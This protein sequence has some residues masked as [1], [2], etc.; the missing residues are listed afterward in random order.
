MFNKHV[1]NFEMINLIAKN[2]IRVRR[3][4]EWLF[5]SFRKI[6]LFRFKSRSILVSVVEFFQSFNFFVVFIFV[7]Y[8]CTQSLSNIFAIKNYSQHCIIQ[9]SIITIILCTYALT[10]FKIKEIR[11]FFIHLLCYYHQK[12]VLNFW[13]DHLITIKKM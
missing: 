1:R 8:I 11:S 5:I 2:V 7:F 13:L 9:I 3:V 10:L 6:R 12:S 4:R